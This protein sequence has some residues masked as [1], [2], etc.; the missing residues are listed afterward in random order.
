[1]AGRDG[2]HPDASSL[3]NSAFPRKKLNMD[4]QKLAD[5]EDDLWDNLYEGQGRDTTETS[6]RYAAYANRLR[7]IMLSAQRYVAYTSDIGESFRPVAHPILVRSAY[8]ISWAYILGDVSHEGWKAYKRNQR[9][10]APHGDEH[11]NGRERET[12]GTVDAIMTRQPVHI[13]AI[14]D[15][16]AVMAQRAV[17]QSIASMGLPAFTIHSI[18]RYSGRALKNAANTTIRT[19]GPIGVSIDVRKARHITDDFSSVLPRFQLYHTCLINL[20]RRL[21]SGLS[22]PRSAPLEVR[23]P[24]GKDLTLAGRR[25]CKSRQKSQPRR[26]TYDARGQTLGWKALTLSRASRLEILMR[27]E[28]FRTNAHNSLTS[29]TLERH[30]FD[31]GATSVLSHPT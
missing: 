31:D 26:R 29:H 1:M 11:F 4:L 9:L 2:E 14:E 6:V 19:W 23:L 18:V 13:P 8:T 30:Q 24:W 16:K 28:F 7:T 21:L 22:I 27:L 5:R 25:L 15:Y 12:M 3:P 10:V 20:S 17:F